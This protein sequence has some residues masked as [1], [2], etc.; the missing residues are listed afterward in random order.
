MAATVP[1]AA[2]AVNRSGVMAGLQNN[3]AGSSCVRSGDPNFGGNL[4][5]FGHHHVV[6]VH[7]G[8][9]AKAIGER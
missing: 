8:R 2:G 5:A 6:D 4:R 7:I 3:L 1:G 9:E